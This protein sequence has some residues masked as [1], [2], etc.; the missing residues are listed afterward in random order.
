MK[1][2]RNVRPVV[3]STEYIVTTPQNSATGEPD[4]RQ[5]TQ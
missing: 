2:K 1:I 3:H 4:V 5:L